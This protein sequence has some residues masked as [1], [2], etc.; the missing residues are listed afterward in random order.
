[1]PRAGVKSPGSAKPPASLF[2]HKAAIGL[3][4][5]IRC[6]IMAGLFEGAQRA[7]EDLQ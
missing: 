4:A 3:F 6:P 2:H 7:I 1:M 5:S